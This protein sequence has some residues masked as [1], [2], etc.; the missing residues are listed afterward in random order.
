ML[1]RRS[2]IPHCDRRGQIPGQDR[3]ADRKEACEVKRGTQPPTTTAAPGLGA[4]SRHELSAL[5]RWNRR[6]RPRGGRR[7]AVT[8]TTAPVSTTIWLTPGPSTRSPTTSTPARA[9]R[10]RRSGC[11]H[12]RRRVAHTL[13]TGSR[14]SIDGGCSS[15][16]R[17]RPNSRPSC[18]EHAARRRS[19][20]HPAPAKTSIRPGSAG[21]D[22]IDQA[23]IGISRPSALT[24]A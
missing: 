1:G 3:R 20:S 6:Y 24:A 19:P 14:S 9:T 4:T 18:P 15:T 13:P 5:E 2:G 7:M 8:H 22:R 23:L 12:W 11:P 16:R 17:R 10:T 21:Q